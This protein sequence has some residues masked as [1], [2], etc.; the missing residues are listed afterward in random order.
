[1]IAPLDPRTRL[2]P[3]EAAAYIR[4]GL[5][6]KTLANWRSDGIGPRYTKVAGAIQYKVADLDA[7]L[8]AHEVAA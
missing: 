8:E 5:S 6:S 2:N 3:A 7:Y 4:D 1:M